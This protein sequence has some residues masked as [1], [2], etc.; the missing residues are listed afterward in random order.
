M[1]SLSD[2]IEGLEQQ[3]E[4]AAAALAQMKRFGDDDYPA[5]TI[6]AFDVTFP[7]QTRNGF[8][9][10]SRTYAY[11]AIKSPDG[12]WQTSGPDRPGPFSWSELV[13]WWTRRR[14]PTTEVWVVTQFEQ[15]EA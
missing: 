12:L 13:Q 5:G 2:T 14:I 3:L 15:V 6:I 1:H 7:A 4:K 9:E 11:A 8:N 10:D